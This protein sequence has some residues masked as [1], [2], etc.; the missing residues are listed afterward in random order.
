MKAKLTLFLLLFTKLFFGQESNDKTIYLD[1]V[2]KETSRGKHKYY[3]VIKD[4]YLDKKS[5]LFTD[6]YLSG[7]TLSQALSS[8]NE[9]LIRDG[10]FITYYENGN[11]KS[12]AT[13]EK[14][15]LN[16]RCSTW[17]EN[18]E[19]RFDGEFIQY[20]TKESNL[21]ILK[22][23]NYWDE[24]ESQKVID[25]NGYFKDDECFF[26]YSDVISEGAI[27]DGFKDGKWVG[28]DKKFGITFEENYENGLL[29]SGTSS[30][31]NNEKHLYTV[32][33]SKP[34]IKG[35][36]AVFYNYIRKNFKAP[37]IPGLKGKLITE[38]IINKNGEITDL[39]IS[40]S[41]NP[42]AD[43]EAI[44]VVSNFKDF[45]PAVW[46]G[47]KIKCSYS[48]PISIETPKD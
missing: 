21:E 42:E 15:I 16:G 47:I 35:G 34:D 30:D 24:N 18:G 6:Y 36:I 8:N 41:L 43:K 26:G 45:T 28:E 38:F 3:R 19:K 48:L 23:M 10:E 37:D 46:R 12:R 14:N 29:K 22:I 1:S 27:K 32:L 20:T 2:F 4:Y 44:R 33:L 13:Y 25:G 31:K 7:K 9:Y 17:Y 40:K 5:Y 39:K 11:K